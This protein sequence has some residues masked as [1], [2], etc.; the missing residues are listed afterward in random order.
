MGK[1]FLWLLHYACIAVFSVQALS[2][3]IQVLAVTD[4]ATFTPGLPFYGSLATVFCTG[5]TGVN[6]VQSATS[7]P[8]PYQI[9]GVSVTISGGI[10]PLLAVADLGSYHRSI[11][12][13][14]DS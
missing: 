1:H 3:Q 14:P 6:G 13:C 11:F 10:A 9:A 12:R 4:A 2:A 5:L 8:L 7:Y